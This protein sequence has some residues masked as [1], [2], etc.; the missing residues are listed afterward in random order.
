MAYYQQSINK[1]FFSFIQLNLEHFSNELQD[2]LYY[3]CNAINISLSDTITITCKI[4]D[5]L[6]ALEKYNIINY[7]SEKTWFQNPQ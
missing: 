6:T 3:Y 5:F 4:D 1:S 2:Y 7:L